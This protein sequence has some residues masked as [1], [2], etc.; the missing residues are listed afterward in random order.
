MGGQPCSSPVVQALRWL[1]REAATDS[2]VVSVLRHRLPDH[3]KRNLLENR[4]DLPG[5]AVS[6]ACGIAG[7]QVVAA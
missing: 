2:Q 5:W 4:R 3:V 7:D 6:L 1:G